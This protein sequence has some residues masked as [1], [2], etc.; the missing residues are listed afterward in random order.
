MLLQEGGPLSQVM[1]A[2]HLGTTQLKGTTA[3][4]TIGMA[5]VLLP[6]MV[7]P[8]YTGMK[9]IDR[10]LV[11]AAGS[12]GATPTTA[13]RLVYLPLS[14]PGIVAALGF[15]VTPVL[16]GSPQ[17]AMISQLIAQKV[18]PL[19]DFPA[20]GAL[21]LI[22]LAVALGLLAAVS[23]VVSASTAL[24]MGGDEEGQ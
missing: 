9:G 16:L 7:L 17:Q 23:R 20:A 4:V 5:Q 22:L 21:S 1:H 8:L 2:L 18:N 11:A 10:N 15:Y 14:M 3:G 13:F 6:F 12:M 24:G 19:L